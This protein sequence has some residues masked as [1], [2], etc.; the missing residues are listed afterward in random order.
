[1][2]EAKG[3]TEEGNDAMGPHTGDRF[4]VIG[5]EAGRGER[6]GLVVE[7]HGDTGGPPYVVRWDDGHE[8]LASL[9]SDD[10]IIRD[11]PDHPVRQPPGAHSDGSWVTGAG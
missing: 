11:G 9:P 3:G 6:S 1:V 5:T 7:E 10:V 8:T 4:V 2:P